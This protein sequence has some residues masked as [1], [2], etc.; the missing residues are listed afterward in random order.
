MAKQVA[1]VADLARLVAEEQ[2]AL[3]E[4]KRK[5]QQLDSE[6]EEL[7]GQVAQLKGSAGRKAAARPAR[8]KPARRPRR[9]RGGKSLREGVAE[10]LSKSDRAMRAREIAEELIKSGY[11]TSSTNPQNMVS[12]LLA[13]SDQFKRVR[14]GLYTV[15]KAATQEGNK[16]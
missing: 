5:R 15:K 10:I 1:T 9:K 7:A 16:K 2:K 13:Q 4:L 8:K 12:A 3:A 14:R 11:V 6:L